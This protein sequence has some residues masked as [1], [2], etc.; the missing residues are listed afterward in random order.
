MPMCR[1]VSTDTASP[2]GYN[3][4]PH[5]CVIATLNGEFLPGQTTMR[6]DGTDGQCDFLS[7]GSTRSQA[8]QMGPPIRHTGSG[9]CGELI[10]GRFDEVFCCSCVNPP[11][12]PPPMPPPDIQLD[13]ASIPVGV[14][15]TIMLRGAGIADE[16]TVAFL[17]VTS[18]K[19]SGARVLSQHGGGGQVSHSLVKG[20]TLSQAGLFKLCV[21][22]STEQSYS[23][24]TGVLLSV[25][26]VQP[27]PSQLPPLSPCPPPLSPPS[28]TPPPPSPHPPHELVPYH[29][30][31]KDDILKTAIEIIA[32]VFAHLC[33]GAVCGATYK[34]CKKR[35]Q[36][37]ALGVAL[38]DTSILVT[39]TN[40]EEP[41]PAASTNGADAATLVPATSTDGSAA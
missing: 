29:M 40:P 12:S 15:T 19:C 37:P 4:H 17:P 20:V 31:E 8:C 22:G 11:A 34:R 14:P 39:S 18:Y 33:L 35:Y 38:L 2:C 27:P 10:W 3:S 9:Y 5:Y 25:H 23:V 13:P 28:P 26:P 41:I 36:T 16:S 1:G 7:T 32:T 30:S 21:A 6:C 24:S